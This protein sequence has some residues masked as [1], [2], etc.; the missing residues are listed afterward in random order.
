MKRKLATY[1]LLSLMAF[2]TAGFYLVFEIN[3]FLVRREMAAKISSGNNTTIETIVVNGKC[4]Y[5]K[6]I[7]QTEI[8]YKGEMYDV[9]CKTS[10]GSSR[11]FFCI[12]DT[13]E[14]KINNG[15]SKM[16]KDQT[17]HLL[18]PVFGTIALLEEQAALPAESGTAVSYISLNRETESAIRSIPETPPKTS[19][20]FQSAV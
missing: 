14:G 20:Y 18:I 17:K 2:H 6:I 9:I 12:H 1:F 11:V 4:D 15:I 13:R 5:L 7:D 3:R 8:E 16:M 10:K 19:P